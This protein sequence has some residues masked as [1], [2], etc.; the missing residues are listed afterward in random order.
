MV[1]DTGP[2]I[3][4]M[5]W[6]QL[7]S[8][9]ILDTRLMY[10]LPR[11]TIW[12]KSQPGSEHFIEFCFQLVKRSFHLSCSPPLSAQ[13]NSVFTQPAVCSSSPNQKA[14]MVPGLESRGLGPHFN[15]Q[16]HFF[17]YIMLLFTNNKEE[18]H[19][20]VDEGCFS[21]L[22][23]ILTPPLSAQFLLAKEGAELSE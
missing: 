2:S 6:R 4:E 13:Q 17:T 5:L 14:I 11:W 10:I 12:T 1:N 23:C 19:V 16:S 9:V 22:L 8:K 21:W 18:I 7:L 3:G 20:V 15:V